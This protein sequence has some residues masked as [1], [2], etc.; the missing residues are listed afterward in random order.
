MLVVGPRNT[1]FHWF[2]KPYC[3]VFAMKLCNDRAP[4]GLRTRA[5]PCLGKDVIAQRKNI[6]G[7]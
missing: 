1:T 2:R 3:T 4:F 5:P 6:D 7:L